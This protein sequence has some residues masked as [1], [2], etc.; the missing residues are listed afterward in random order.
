VGMNI[1]QL[2]IEF[3]KL[4]W[5]V[6]DY[7]KEETFQLRKHGNTDNNETIY[8]LTELEEKLFEWQKEE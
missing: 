1:E 2:R 7:Y 4:G 8:N 6:M 5:Q 3:D